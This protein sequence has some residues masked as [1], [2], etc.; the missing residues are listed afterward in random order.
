MKTQN[1]Y[2]QKCI[3]NRVFIYIRVYKDT[4]RIF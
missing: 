3:K 4:E 2:T 1:T